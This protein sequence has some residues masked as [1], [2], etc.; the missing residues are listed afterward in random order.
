M[1]IDRDIITFTALLISAQM[2]VEMIQSQLIHKCIYSVNFGKK[3]PFIKQS[4]L[5]VKVT[6]PLLTF[7]L[8]HNLSTIE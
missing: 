1:I 2:V 4:K 3:Y 8:L 5:I 6:L 7:S